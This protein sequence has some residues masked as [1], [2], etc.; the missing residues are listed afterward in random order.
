MDTCSYQL[1]FSQITGNTKKKKPIFSFH[2]KWLLKAAVS[3][4]TIYWL[5]NGHEFFYLL[6]T[7][8]GV[9]VFHIFMW[10][11]LEM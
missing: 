9:C 10:E 8:S 5:V 6:V 1:T 4:L 7:T 11:S 3:N 2:Q